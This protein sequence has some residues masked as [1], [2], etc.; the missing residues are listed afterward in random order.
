MVLSVHMQRPDDT[1]F[2]LDQKI[3]VPVQET[4]TLFVAAP[5]DLFGSRGIPLSEHIFYLAGPKA[6]AERALHQ[7]C[8]RRC[9]QLCAADPGEKSIACGAVA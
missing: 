3:K 9:I 5:L 8:Q 1:V 6:L 4:R 2:V 7:P